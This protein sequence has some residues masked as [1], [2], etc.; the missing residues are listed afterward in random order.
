MNTLPINHKTLHSHNDVVSHFSLSFWAA[1]ALTPALLAAASALPSCF[2]HTGQHCTTQKWIPVH[3]CAQGVPCCINCQGTQTWRSWKLGFAAAF[4][5]FHLQITGL[6]ENQGS[7]WTDRSLL[8]LR[9]VGTE[10]G[11]AWPPL[12]YWRKGRAAAWASFACLADGRARALQRC[13]RG[14]PR[15]QCPGKVAQD[16]KADESRGTLTWTD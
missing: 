3:T 11:T 8:F 7:E 2:T 9:L 15:R 16:E 4:S 10:T 6:L 14:Q 12:L 1:E 5:S 13:C